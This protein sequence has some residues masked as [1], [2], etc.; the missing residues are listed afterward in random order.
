M[1]VRPPRAL[2]WGAGA[3]LPAAQPEHAGLRGEVEQVR[4]IEPEKAVVEII[5]WPEDKP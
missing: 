5:A 2:A 1:R 4:T 3:S